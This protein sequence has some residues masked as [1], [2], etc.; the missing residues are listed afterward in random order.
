MSLQNEQNQQIKCPHCRRI[1]SLNDFYTRKN[2]K[3]S[4]PCKECSRTTHRNRYY[5]IKNQILRDTEEFKA[6]RRVISK[7]W[8]D[9][10]PEKRKQIVENHYFQKRGKVLELLGNICFICGEIPKRFNCHEIHN[11][12]HPKDW[13]YIL[14]HK[15]DF[16]I[17]CNKC[18]AN[19]HFYLKYLDKFEILKRNVFAN[20][21]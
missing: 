4:L 1:K 15:D 5:E 7:R 18:H 19:F 6:K 2:G 12:K 17:L 21:G 8:M 13:N 9:S 11:K 16:V 3:L 20:K 10:F 14:T